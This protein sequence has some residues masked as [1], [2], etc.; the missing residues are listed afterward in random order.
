MKNLLLNKVKWILEEVTCSPEPL[1]LQ[2]LAESSGIPVPTV[3]RISSDLVEMGLLEKVGYHHFA[4]GPGLVS[5]GEIAK[6]NNQLLKKTEPL[7]RNFAGSVNMNSLLC[8]FYNGR[9]FQLFSS[10][11]VEVSPHLPWRTGSAIMLLAAAKIGKEKALEYFISE[12]PDADGAEKLIFE[13]EFDNAALK[14]NLFRINSMRHWSISLPFFCNDI[15]YTLC[16]YGPAPSDRTQERFSF[17]CSILISK[18][19][20]AIQEN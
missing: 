5:L 9:I 18:I 6:N 19:K 2:Q 11:N 14:R 1:S 20:S 10:G 12:Y 7:I 15:C 4:P 3:S 16:F 17:D 8:G 13:R